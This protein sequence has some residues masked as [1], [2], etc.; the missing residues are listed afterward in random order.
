MSELPAV[1]LYST[2]VPTLPKVR[3]D[4][5]TIK[6]ILEA[7][8]VSYEEVRWCAPLIPARHCRQLLSHCLLSVAPGSPPGLAC[9]HRSIH[10]HA[11]VAVMLNVLT[12]STVRLTCQHSLSSGGRCWQAVTTT[13]SCHSYTSTAR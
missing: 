4:I 2:S 7:K 5:A 13:P 3:A 11:C 9:M 10:K 1:V 12:I 6:R 8:K